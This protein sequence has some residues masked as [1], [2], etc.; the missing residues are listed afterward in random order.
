MFLGCPNGKGIRQLVSSLLVTATKKIAVLAGDGIGREVI[1][2]AM[3]VMM[4]SG[5]PIET[6]EFDWGAARY[7]ADGVTV[8]PDG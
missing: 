2:Q 4:A 7:L 8:P 6:T 1:P 5:A 3:K